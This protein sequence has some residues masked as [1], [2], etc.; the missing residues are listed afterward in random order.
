MSERS[1]GRACDPLCADEHVLQDPLSD[2]HSELLHLALA[3]TDGLP[4]VQWS[5][6]VGT[7]VLYLIFI[8]DGKQF[9][10]LIVSWPIEQ[11]DPI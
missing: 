9:G 5:S 11:A 2:R 6:A 8:V 7:Q 1:V 3:G 4:P 10:L